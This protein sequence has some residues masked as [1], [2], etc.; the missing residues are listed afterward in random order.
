MI[1]ALFNN[2][3]MW[4]HLLLLAL[5]S[6]VLLSPHP[7]WSETER[8]LYSYNDYWKKII[9]RKEKSNTFSNKTQT[10]KYIVNSAIY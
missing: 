2:L 9:E 10:V 4:I 5:L 7:S 3:K 6:E 1:Q 8:S